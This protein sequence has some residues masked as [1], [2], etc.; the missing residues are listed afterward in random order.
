MIQE[1]WSSM[2][3]LIGILAANQHWTVG[4]VFKIDVTVLK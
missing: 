2:K 3:Q 1:G 4:H